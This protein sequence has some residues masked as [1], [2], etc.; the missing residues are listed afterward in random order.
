[1]DQRPPS[2]AYAAALGMTAA[3]GLSFVATKYALRGFQPMLVA[4]LRF[5]LAGG[6]LWIVWRLRRERERVTRHELARLAALG[7]VSLTLYFAFETNGIARTS[8]SKAALII[9][10]IPIFVAV[11]AALVLGERAGPRR[12]AGI[13]VSFAGVA[14]LVLLGGGEGGG[15]LTGDLLGLAAALTAAVYNLM[16]RSLLL[17][18]SALYVTAFQN[19]FGALFMLPIAVAEA[20]LVGVRDPTGEAGLGVL[21]LAIFSSTLAYLL[22]NYAFRFLEASLVA[23]FVNLTPVVGV[24]AAYVLLGERFTSGQAVAA[25]VVMAGVWLANSGGGAEKAPVAG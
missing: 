22:L 14:A 8:A 3:F 11:L 20:I 7:F 12:W 10:T 17:T 9:A 2:S 25:L 23:V 24:A 13:V 18:R 6:L 1:V 16:A 4:L 21:Y 15:S 5:S 19:L